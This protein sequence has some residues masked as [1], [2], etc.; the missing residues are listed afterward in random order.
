MRASLCP[1]PLNASAQRTC[2]P[3]RLILSQELEEPDWDAFVEA[4]PLGHYEQTSKWAR[5]KAIYG[6]RPIRLKLTSD[7]VPVA[8]AQVL[9]KRLPASVGIGYL[10]KGPV[11]DSSELTVLS[12]LLRHG[13]RRGVRVRPGDRSDISS[14]CEMMLNKIE[15]GLPP[16][17]RIAASWIA[18]Q[19]QRMG[20]EPVFR[21][22]ITAGRH[23]RWA[24]CSR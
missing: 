7:K 10:T 13:E 22:M 1:E 2:Q 20:L 12:T 17:P 23:G 21:H 8:G 16:I 4:S 15:S 24:G 11:L 19:G 14:F 9:V 6:W 3:L 5:A 18:A